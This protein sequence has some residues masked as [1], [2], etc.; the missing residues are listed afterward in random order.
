MYFRVIKF[1]LV[2]CRHYGG[3]RIYTEEFGD[4]S[5]TS[6]NLQENT[7]EA[8][9]LRDST[10]IFY[11]KLP[12]T[13]TS[14][15]DLYTKSIIARWHDVQRRWVDDEDYTDYIPA[16]YENLQCLSIG[17]MEIYAGNMIV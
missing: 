16:I 15:R 4:L 9:D 11:F 2:L 10:K 1:L 13:A 17:K 14:D 3:N 7:I 8:C 12:E 5:V 6:Y